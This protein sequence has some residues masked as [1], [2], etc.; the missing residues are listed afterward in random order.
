MGMGI[1]GFFSK[2]KPT[3]RAVVD[4][5][6][7]SI[8]SLIF[9]VS[10][11][12]RRN[13][14]ILRKIF[15]KL[16]L[17]RRTADIFNT[18]D[19]RSD[20]SSLV[21]TRLREIM[22]AMVREF[23]RVP[24]RIVIG[25]GPNLAEHSLMDWSI[26]PL[27][28]KKIGT[29][30][31]LGRYFKSLMDLHRDE[32]SRSLIYPLNVLVNGYSL[33]RPEYLKKIEED[34]SLA[35]PSASSSRK[36][37]ETFPILGE[38]TFRVFNLSFQAEVGERLREMRES[39]GGMPIEF[40]PLSAVHRMSLLPAFKLENALAV[41]IG[42]EH[43]TL[44]FYQKGEIAEISGF[45]LGAHHFIQGIAKLFNLSFEEAEDEKRRYAQG[46]LAEGRKEKLREFILQESRLWEEKFREAVDAMYH[47]GPL[48][49]D[50]LLFGGGARLQEIV[51]ILREPE[52][53]AANSY[54]PAPRVKV[55]DASSLF[56]GNS[57]GGS[58]QGPEEVG[59]ASL[60]HYTLNYEPIL[61]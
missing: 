10:S 48:P 29:R 25:I 34:K 23:E 17:R 53:F 43:T 28:H 30:E 6:S 13:I 59:L 40:V 14:R 21:V 1:L 8:K 7:H 52:W 58:L 38:I 51:S 16:S 18:K 3:L 41:D 35:A 31:D 46:L 11:D 20:V 49:P 5:G 33:F 39:L 27:H 24:E 42:G 9:E 15:S 36:M 45:P 61:K 26:R 56:Q 19:A 57:F 60:M 55:V 37:L 2:K 4:V 32:I 54:A 47:V 44:S 22:F 50:V 12:G